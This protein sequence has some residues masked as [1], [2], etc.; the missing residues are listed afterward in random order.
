MKECTPSVNRQLCRGRTIPQWKRV[1]RTLHPRPLRLLHCPDRT[2]YR[3]CTPPLFFDKET[4]DPSARKEI[5]GR[6]RV[7]DSPRDFRHS[8]E[9][10]ICS[11]TLVTGLSA[12]GVVKTNNDNDDCPIT[13]LTGCRYGIRNNIRSKSIRRVAYER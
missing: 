2:Q 12:G 8:D 13:I 4:Q 1:G 11:T 10:F 7:T 5:R 9:V 3:D 6:P